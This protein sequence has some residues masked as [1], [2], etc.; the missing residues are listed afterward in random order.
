MKILSELSRFGE[1]RVGHELPQRAFECGNVQL[2]LYNAS[3]WNGHR[4]HFD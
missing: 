1:L 2:M 4:I 3:L